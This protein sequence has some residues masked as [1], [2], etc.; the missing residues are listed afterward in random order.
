[1][2]KK[3]RMDS[4]ITGTAG[5]FYVAAEIAKRG[6]IATLTLKNTPLIDVLATNSKKG[7]FANIQVKTRSIQNKQGWVFTKKVGERSN[8]KNHFY[9]FVNLKEDELSDYYIVPFNEFADFIVDKNKRWLS[10]KGR[11]GAPR[12]ENSVRNFKPEKGHI[13]FYEADAKLG[14]KY[15]DKWEI[16]G[17]FD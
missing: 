15:K 8:I 1:M 2:P 17:I 14:S 10:E 16:L 13:P 5:E 3:S 12:K 9:V 6:G 11:G 7:S 4:A